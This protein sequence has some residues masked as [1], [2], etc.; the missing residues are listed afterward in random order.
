MKKGL[1][2]IFSILLT[3][4]LVV[5]FLKGT[6][7]TSSRSGTPTV[8]D[9][10]R[11]E[12][13]EFWDAYHTATDLRTAGD[14]R[15]AAGYYLSA[16]RFNPDHQ[17]SLYYLGN[18]YMALGDYAQA[19]KM[20]ERLIRINSS[21]SRGYSQLGILYSCREAG[22]NLY[23]LD[24][25]ADHFRKA[26]RLNREET[27]PLLQLA[28]INLA[29]S[30]LVKAEKQLNDVA[31]SNF[32][33]SEALF[34]QGYLAWKKDNMQVADT[35]LKQSVSIVTGT[36]IKTNVGEGETRKGASPLITE[37]YECNI[38]TRLIHQLLREAA[39]NVVKADLIYPQFD[40]AFRS[41]Y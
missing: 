20:W 36:T 40:Q 22:N 33:S 37:S 12:V 38:Y 25:A 41:R 23:N 3:A 28:K 16:L 8:P 31:S 17:N 19:E 15:G 11:S 29:K 18:M 32:R 24:E 5:T 34:L 26:S 30:R 14:Y 1:I 7:E 27:G 13:V 6:P 2:G 9:S 4:F 10:S 39:Q 35:L 21:S